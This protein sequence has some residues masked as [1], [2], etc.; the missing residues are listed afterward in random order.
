MHGTPVIKS[1]AHKAKHW[2]WWLALGLISV[3]YLTKIF[4]PTLSGDFRTWV[5]RVISSNGSWSHVRFQT[6]ASN[7]LSAPLSQP[8]TLGVA[9]GWHKDRGSVRFVPRITVYTT[10]ISNVLAPASAKVLSVNGHDLTLSL[11]TIRVQFLGLRNVLVHPGQVVLARQTLGQMNGAIQIAVTR[12]QLPVNPLAP[13]YFGT[14][15][16]RH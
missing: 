11:G 10:G 7:P 2:K 3:I 13:E 12:D 16:L 6:P 1:S 14:D 4:P 5:H 15:W 8:A 9:F